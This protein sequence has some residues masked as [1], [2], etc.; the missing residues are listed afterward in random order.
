M[1]H[2]GFYGDDEVDVSKLSDEEFQELIFQVLS[3]RV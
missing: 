1:E 3:K 2:W